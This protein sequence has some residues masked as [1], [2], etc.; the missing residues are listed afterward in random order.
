MSH[1]YIQARYTAQMPFVGTP[2]QRAFIDEQAKA[3]GVSRAEILR[4]A[5]DN[6]ITEQ[7][8]AAA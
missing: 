3:D 6:Y 5:L 2:E 1:T 4:R 7:K 8:E